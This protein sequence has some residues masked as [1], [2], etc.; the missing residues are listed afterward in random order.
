LVENKVLLILSLKDMLFFFLI[1]FFQPSYFL[2]IRYVNLANVLWVSLD[3]HFIKLHF[4][5][6][7][8]MAKEKLQSPFKWA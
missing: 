1:F 6:S 5:A 2:F 7:N 4:K 8:E 3:P